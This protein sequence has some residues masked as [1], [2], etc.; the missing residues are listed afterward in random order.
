MINHGEKP[1]GEQYCTI[2]YHIIGEMNAKD[3]AHYELG[4]VFWLRRLVR[5]L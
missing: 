4:W 5:T 2:Y 3:G 1:I